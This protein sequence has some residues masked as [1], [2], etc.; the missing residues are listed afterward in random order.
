MIPRDLADVIRKRLTEHKVIV[1]YGARQVGKTTLLHQLLDN[2]AE[3]V[4]W[5]NAD[6]P[7]I[8][9]RFENASQLDLRSMVGQHKI[10]VIDEA[11]RIPNIGISIKLLHDNYPEITIVLT[12]SSALDL[13]STIKE[14]LTGRKWEY[15]LYP[16]SYHELQQ[17]FG[18]L[19]EAEMLPQR[20]VF[21]SY[22]EVVTSNIGDQ[23]ARLI[24]L[25]DS[26][27]F[28]DI[29]ALRD[30]KRP[31]QLEKLLKALAYQVGS[32]VSYNELA[33]TAGLDNETVVRYIDL[34]EQSYVIFRV[35]AF[36]RN[37]RN[38]IR[39]SRKIY[40]Y[41]NGI[42]NTLIGNHSDIKTRAD[43]GALWENY[44]VSER[45]KFNQY[46]S[47]YCN[48]YF[49]RTRMQQ[50][51]DYI[52]ESNGKLKA[53]EFKWNPKRKVIVS[54]TF[55]NAYPDSEFQVITPKNYHDFLSLV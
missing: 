23:K 41:D 47:S 24:Q 32:E 5:M 22:P 50:E 18:F 10:L 3:A 7:P 36:S 11:Q 45:Q 19:K 48:A 31:T 33:R 49:W 29:L 26:Y 44:L 17:H 34:L 6:N 14:P 51:I 53:F 21:G 38:E 20:L 43:V 42:R 16:L 40:F 4:L 12:G 1:L 39:K 27:L 30:V 9:E 8:R 25:T 52:E 13:Q 15:Q 35:R 46:T 55:S 54:K 28:K 2:S 37:L